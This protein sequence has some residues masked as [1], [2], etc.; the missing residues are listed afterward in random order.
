MEM[1]RR[2]VSREFKLEAVNGRWENA[3]GLGFRAISLVE[4]R[5]SRLWSYPLHPF[6]LPSFAP[7][8]LGTLPRRWSAFVFGC[9]GNFEPTAEGY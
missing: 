3:A 8:R 5:I 1:Q 9:R 4:R 7:P 6:P 2:K